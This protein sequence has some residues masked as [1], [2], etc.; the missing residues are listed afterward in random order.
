M[1]PEGRAMAFGVF[2]FSQAYCA[3]PIMGRKKN[4]SGEILTAYG[5]ILYLCGLNVTNL[6]TRK[7]IES[8]E[9]KC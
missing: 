2:A 5:I 4:I 9:K 6:E 7:C 8:S 3:M 1:D